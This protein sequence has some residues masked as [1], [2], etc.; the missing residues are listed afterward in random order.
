MNEYNLGENINNQGG[1]K[2][3]ELLWS[4]GVALKIQLTRHP[5]P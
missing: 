4:L 3:N 5:I 2:M 1:N